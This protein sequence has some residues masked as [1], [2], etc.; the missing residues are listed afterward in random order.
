M[1]RTS[2][3]AEKDA[4]R[5]TARVM[6]A[7]SLDESPPAAAALGAAAAALERM[8]GI[9]PLIHAAL[10]PQIAAALAAWRADPTWADH[11]AAAYSEAKVMN[12]V[13]ID[14][15]MRSRQIAAL[16]DAPAALH[17]AVTALRDAVAIMVRLD[18]RWSV[19]P[20]L[21][22]LGADGWRALEADQRNALLTRAAP[23]ELGCIWG[24]LD[25]K[26]RTATV[27][28]LASVTRELADTAAQ[29]LAAQARA[30]AEAWTEEAQGETDPEKA[31]QI[32]AAADLLAHAALLAEDSDAA[33][34]VKAVHE[35]QAAAIVVM[36]AAPP[37][38]VADSVA[39]IWKVTGELD[40]LLAEEASAVA[41]FIGRIGAD[42][43]K[44]FDANLR[45]RLINIVVRPPRP[46]L[47]TA[48][49]WSGMTHDERDLLT[50]A[51]VKEGN[52]MVALLLL[53]QMGPEGRK[54]LSVQQND[55]ITTLAMKAGNAWSVASLLAPVIGWDALSDEVRRT[56]IE[57]METLSSLASDVLRGAGVA[58]W[59]AMSDDVRRRFI[60]AVR[61]VPQ[62]IFRCPPALWF[63]IAGDALHSVRHI[64]WSDV[65]S[66]H[67]EDA[68]ADLGNVSKMH[69]ALVLAL[70]PWRIEDVAPDSVRM[71]RLSDVWNA[72]TEE[73]RVDLVLAHPFVLA[74]VAAA[75]RVC[76]GPEAARAAV[77]ETA[78]RVDA[79][80][81]HIVGNTPNS[82]LYSGPR[83][84]RG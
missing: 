5:D 60:A 61:S 1:N 34:R 78:A 62:A 21:E 11:I 53:K 13:L 84:R 50:T 71:R 35:A 69:Q 32:A 38:P 20:C 77:G 7:V 79:A 24:A 47:S 25:E 73:E 72:L 56:V 41:R 59:S 36:A 17:D 45:E 57:E 51:L 6:T 3:D 44:A 82:A 49:A 9:E 12:V 70:A 33:M 42:G 76:G 65:M 43:W 22:A 14:I 39:A 80:W 52:G 48:P 31:A 40:V 27:N 28:A 67:A 63:D 83:F 66:W 10:A 46:V 18:Q 19:A 55:K 30:A 4:D 75:A 2:K 54:N 26:Q 15:S 23:D 81:S 8:R 58:G 64:W 16:R 37:A 74:A 68:D 29:R